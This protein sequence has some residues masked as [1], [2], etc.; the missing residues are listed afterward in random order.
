MKAEAEARACAPT[1]APTPTPDWTND[2]MHVITEG[3]GAAIVGPGYW[4]WARTENEAFMWKKYL[5]EPMVLE[6]TY[7]YDLLMKT[8]ALEP[9]DGSML[10]P[11]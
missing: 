8:M 6:N 3:R 7:D 5:G 9:D 10:G 1:P 2:M 4:H 11:T